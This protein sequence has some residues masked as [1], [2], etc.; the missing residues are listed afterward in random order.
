MKIQMINNMRKLLL[1][2]ILLMFINICNGQDTLYHKLIINGKLVVRDSSRFKGDVL[3]NGNLVYPHA[4]TV[5]GKTYGLVF[6]GTTV[7]QQAISTTIPFNGNR[8]VKRAGLPLINAGGTD[9]QTWV[10]N[11]F[12]PFVPATITCTSATSIVEAGS[13][14]SITVSGVTTA[15]DETIF[16]IGVLNR[17]LPLP[18]SLLTFFG[19]ALNYSHVYSYSPLVSEVLQFQATQLTGNNGSPLLIYSPL[20]NINAVYT[21]LYGVSANDYSG[22]GNPAYTGLT[23]LIQVQ[24]SKTISLTGTNGYI[25]FAYPASYGNLTSIIDQN[26]FDVTPSFTKYTAN[27]TSSGLPNNYTISY[28]IYKLNSTTSPAAWSYHFNY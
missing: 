19:A 10:E 1:L 20:K 21:Y 5:T 6:D 14:T 2:P 26:G 12:F 25:Y 16:S 28:F 11:Y 23:K 3:I 27:I 8:A 18:V 15:N 22:G 7:K 13:T 9:L 4:D 24:G 17:N